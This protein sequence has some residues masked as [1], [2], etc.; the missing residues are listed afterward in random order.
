[1]RKLAITLLGGAVALVGAAAC[2][3]DDVSENIAEE[4][5]EEAG[6]A[7]EVD[8]E[9]GGDIPDCFPD[10]TPVPEGDPQGGFGV[11]EGDE[12]VCSFIVNVDGDVNDAVN[13]YKSELEDDGW[14]IG[15]EAE[16]ADANSFGA[17][18]GDV[19]L[20]V[21]GSSASGQATISVTAGTADIAG[22][23]PP[24]S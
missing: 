11:G 22:N 19:G 13:S 6:D 8:I 9:T 2:D 5:A 4:I 14:E 3:S 21:A 17:S 12:A 16:A 1:M 20:L 23:V 15:F 18:M 24:A 10:D 7:G